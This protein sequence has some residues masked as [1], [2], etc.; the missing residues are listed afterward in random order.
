MKAKMRVIGRQF[1]PARHQF[2]PYDAMTNRQFEAEVIAALDAAKQ[3]KY[4]SRK[5][6]N[7]EN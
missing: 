2:D 1:G 6:M 7:E 3:L 5:F 4:R